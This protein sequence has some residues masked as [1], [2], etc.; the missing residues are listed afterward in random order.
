MELLNTD[1]PTQRF[2]VPCMNLNNEETEITNNDLEFINYELEKFLEAEAEEIANDS[3]ESSQASIITLS[4]KQIEGADSEGTN[5]VPCPLQNYR[6]G[7]L[8]E[9]A[10]TGVEAKK[11]KDITWG[12]L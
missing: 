7:S 9:P 1:P 3:S 11:E 5:T 10:G 2:T 6:F 12:P 4:N 8:I